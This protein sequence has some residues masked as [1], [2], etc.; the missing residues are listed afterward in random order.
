MILIVANEIKLTL[1]VMIIANLI[2][3]FNSNVFFSSNQTGIF[4]LIKK[5]CNNEI[6]LRRLDVE[7]PVLYHEPINTLLKWLMMCQNKFDYVNEK[8]DAKR[9]KY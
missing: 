5:F 6:I 4:I 1:N 9:Q 2:L 3:K 7:A 8:L